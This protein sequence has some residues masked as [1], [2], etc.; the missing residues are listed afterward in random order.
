MSSTTAELS[1]KAQEAA[2]ACAMPEAQGRSA[3]YLA[4]TSA[5]GSP[6]RAQHAEVARRLFE[7]LGADALQRRAEALIDS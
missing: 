6:E 7:A 2:A 5:A 1:R 3:L 4:E